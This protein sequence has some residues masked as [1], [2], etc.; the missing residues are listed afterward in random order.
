MVKKIKWHTGVEKLPPRSSCLKE[1]ER[2]RVRKK[3][4]KRERG[5]MKE[6]NKERINK[7]KGGR[8]GKLDQF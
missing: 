4:Q 7:R 8:N 2:Q 3:E 5:R 1:R 6:I